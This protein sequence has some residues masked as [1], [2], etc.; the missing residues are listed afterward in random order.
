ML[1]GWITTEV[2]RQP[3]TVY[4]L[5]TDGRLRLGDRRGRSGRFAGGVHPRLFRGVRAGTFYIL[6]L[7]S[8]PPHSG[9]R[10]L[11]RDEPCVPAASCRRPPWKQPACT[12]Q[13]EE[14]GMSS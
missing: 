3:Y 1:A 6:R 12:R 8:K 4:G 2:G 10:D 5:L 9:E 11:P 14:P 7:M 13:V